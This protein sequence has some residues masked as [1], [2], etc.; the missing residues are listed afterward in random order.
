MQNEK[1]VFTALANNDMGKSKYQPW[2][3]VAGF[4]VGVIGLIVSVLNKNH[5]GSFAFSMFT[6]VYGFRLLPERKKEPITLAINRKGFHFNN[7]ESNKYH[8]WTEIKMAKYNG[9]YLDMY[10]GSSFLKSI[11]LHMFTE[12]D[13]VQILRLSGIYLAENNVFI[14]EVIH[15]KPYITKAFS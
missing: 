10:W 9:R 2:L 12:N 3:H 11:D 1:Y 14:A 15:A 8:D 7:T 5:S 13:R 6:L 4:S